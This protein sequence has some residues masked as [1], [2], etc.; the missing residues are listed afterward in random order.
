[1]ENLQIKTFN[2]TAVGAVVNIVLNLF[3][4][5]R[6]AA[7]GAAV[8]TLISQV[9]SAYLVD[10]MSRKTYVLFVMKSKSLFVINSVRRLVRRG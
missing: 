8:A 10:L 5:P 7:V 1:M 6:Y 4:I 3:L 2:R 9:F